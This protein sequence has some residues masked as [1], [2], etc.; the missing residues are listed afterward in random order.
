MPAFRYWWSLSK[1]VC[2]RFACSTAN[3]TMGL[4]LVPQVVHGALLRSRLLNASVAAHSLD[5]YLDAYRA[6]AQRLRLRPHCQHR[7][8]A[9]LA[10]KH[11][12]GRL[13]LS[14]HL[15]R[16]D[17]GGATDKGG[18]ASY[19]A[20]A[21]GPFGIENRTQLSIERLV[22]ILDED[23]TAAHWLLISDNR[24]I[25]SRTHES[26]LR[27]RAPYSRQ[28]AMVA[29]P[30]ATQQLFFSMSESDGIVQSVLAHGG[31]SSY[32]S[33]A[34]MLKGTPLL[35]LQLRPDKAD[36]SRYETI[37]DRWPRGDDAVAAREKLFYRTNGEERAFLAA[38]RLRHRQQAEARIE[39][40]QVRVAAAAHSA[41]KRRCTGNKAK[42]LARAK[43]LERAGCDGWAQTDALQTRETAS[44][45]VPSSH[46]SSS[47]RQDPTIVHQ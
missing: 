30:D 29:P 22:R 37:A 41:G 38:A 39:A 44:S 47:D 25:A 19:Y 6:L 43:T 21:N 10:S 2:S 28:T 8:G 4:E 33:V 12:A 1:L 16:T 13:V 18:G 40:R 14:V 9:H 23:A 3:Y 24:T 15:R 5:R 20:L 11:A 31:W 35:S 17:R 26:I 27:A 7:I 42:G 34:A 32:S 46:A 45:R 36:S